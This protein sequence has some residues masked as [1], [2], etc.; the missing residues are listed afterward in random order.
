[1]VAAHCVCFEY[2]VLTVCL[3]GLPPPAVGAPGS[4]EGEDCLLT[5]PEVV[6]HQVRLSSRPSENQLLRS[7]FY[8]EQVRIQIQAQ[9]YVWLDTTQT[10]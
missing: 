9:L 2:C 7:E 5:L 1:M 3:V 10:H 4:G 8:Y 6:Q